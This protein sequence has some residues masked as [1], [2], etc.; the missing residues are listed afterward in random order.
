MNNGVPIE[1]AEIIYD[2]YMKGFPGIAQYQKNM[3]REVMKKGYILISPT[4]GTK[5]F[6]YDFK[7]LKEIEAQFSSE[8]WSTYRDLKISDLTCKTVQ[9]VQHYFSRKNAT[10]KQAVNY[11]IQGT[12]ALMV[13]IA[14]V[15][16]YNYIVSKGLLFKILINIL[17]HDE[18]NVEC[19]EEYVEE[20][21][22]VLLDCMKKAG[23][24]FCPI[25]PCTASLSVGDHWIH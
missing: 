16:F 11:P 1:Q 23:D 10:E 6:I 8:F 20:T 22:E 12:G 18:I 7:N 17:V 21:S 5:C 13:K 14:T 19:P 9:D 4:I 24:I 25:I 2:N 15:K 3:K